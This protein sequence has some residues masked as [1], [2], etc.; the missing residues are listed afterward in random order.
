MLY[1]GVI[2]IEDR[3]YLDAAVEIARMQGLVEAK[4]QEIARL[5]KP[6]QSTPSVDR[7]TAVTLSPLNS[8]R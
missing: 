6:N 1:Q 8:Q 5:S 2:W 3:S 4:D 7:V